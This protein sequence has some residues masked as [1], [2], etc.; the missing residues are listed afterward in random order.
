M[1]VQWHTS[2]TWTDAMTCCSNQVSAFRNS[3][4][5]ECLFMRGFTFPVHVCTC[6][7][8]SLQE[9]GTPCLYTLTQTVA[10]L[11]Q[12]CTPES[13][14]EWI[15]PLNRI[16]CLGKGQARS[17]FVTPMGSVSHAPH[18][19]SALK[20]QRIGVFQ[21]LLST[22]CSASSP[23]DDKCKSCQNTAPAAWELNGKFFVHTDLGWPN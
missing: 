10:Y 8:N 15:K 22:L 17:S 7:G 16:R 18:T 3:L 13:I 12:L 1:C 2:F 20:I 5:I 4:L 23:L 6:H 21:P 19:H 9:S 14:Y 11:A